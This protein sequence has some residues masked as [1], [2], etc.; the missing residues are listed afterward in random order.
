MNFPKSRRCWNSQSWRAKQAYQRIS[1]KSCSET[2][3]LKASLCEHMQDFLEKNSAPKATWNLT[4]WKYI[5]TTNEKLN[6][7][8]LSFESGFKH[9]IFGPKVA[10]WKIEIQKKVNLKLNSKC[11]AINNLATCHRLRRQKQ[12]YSRVSLGRE[13][14]HIWLPNWI[15][16]FLFFSNKNTNKNKNENKNSNTNKKCFFQRLK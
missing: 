3:S 13:T 11:I 6:I 1:C 4:G 9:F 8:F 12:F 2:F 15:N 10:D 5:A 14:P 16:W 7:S